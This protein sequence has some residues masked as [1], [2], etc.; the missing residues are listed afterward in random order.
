MSAIFKSSILLI[1]AFLVVEP[2]V[3]Q[4][5]DKKAA[6]V[7]IVKKGIAIL[8]GAAHLEKYKAATFSE[9]GVYY[10][11]GEGLPYTGKYAVEYPDKFR[12][13]IVGIFTQVLNG[14][15]GWTEMGGEAKAMTKAQ[16]AALREQ[17]YVG[18]LTQ[19]LPLLDKKYTLELTGDGKVS[20]QGVAF[21]KVSAKG[22]RDVTL[23]INPKTG[24]VVKVE[25]KAAMEGM[26][27]KIV[28]Y[29]GFYDEYKTAGKIK[30][31]SKTRSTRAG[32]KFVE[33]TITDFKPLESV[34][35][36]LFTIPKK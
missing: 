34:D 7:K 28:T 32:K 20:G 24:A 36:S 9:T 31:A 2:S 33:S 27:D 22:H 12:M 5:A 6:A 17:H 26:P 1:G 16:V 19:L 11:M 13:E 14:E 21:I 35:A 8:G 30:Y 23:A 29:E 18:K 4:S 15:K 3:L 10:G 25:Y